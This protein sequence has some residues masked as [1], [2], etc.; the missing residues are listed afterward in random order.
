[1]NNKKTIA[2]NPLTSKSKVTGSALKVKGHTAPKGSDQP[3]TGHL[4]QKS[5]K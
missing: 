3:I 2:K 1:M 4:K 5:E